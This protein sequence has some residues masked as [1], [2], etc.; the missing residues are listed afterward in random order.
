MCVSACRQK[1]AAD[2]R[3]G[4]LEGT[5]ATLNVGEHSDER[6]RQL[7]DERHREYVEQQVPAIFFASL[8]MGPVPLILGIFDSRKAPNW[9]FSRREI[10][11]IGN[12]V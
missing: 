8:G 3:K 1:E 4:V 10:R 5:G 2:R 12:S 6:K 9:E 7:Q 11:L